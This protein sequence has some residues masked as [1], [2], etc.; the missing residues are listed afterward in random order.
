[1]L[2]FHDFYG[3]LRMAEEPIVPNQWVGGEGIRFGTFIDTFGLVI[4]LRLEEVKIAP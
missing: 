3:V 2:L 4:A 1:M